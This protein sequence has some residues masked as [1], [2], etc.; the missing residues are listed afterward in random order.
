MSHLRQSPACPGRAVSKQLVVGCPVG[1]LA[2]RYA[3]LLNCGDIWNS[4]CSCQGTTV[5]LV[6]HQLR[7]SQLKGWA[8]LPGTHWRML[9][10]LLP[11]CQPCS[12]AILGKN[13]GLCCL[14][15][16]EGTH[17]FC[18]LSSSALPLWPYPY[19]TGSYGCVGAPGPEAFIICHSVLPHFFCTYSLFS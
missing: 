14:H 7:Y 17:C 11:P 13:L 2:T 1:L 19:V 12:Y 4:S 5:F 3:C 10:V 15:S 6:P 8:Y 16:P 18:V 9:T